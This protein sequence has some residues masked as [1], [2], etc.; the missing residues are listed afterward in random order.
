MILPKGSFLGE[1]LALSLKPSLVCI[2]NR[3]TREDFQDFFEMQ[4]E[5]I[6]SRNYSDSQQ[7]AE[8]DNSCRSFST[9]MQIPGLLEA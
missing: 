9:D 2:S 5:A 7:L 1:L 3:Q 6:A 4:H 8:G